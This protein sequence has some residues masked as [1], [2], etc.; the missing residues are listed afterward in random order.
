MTGDTETTFFRYWCRGE[1]ELKAMGTGIVGLTAHRD[2]TRAPGLRVVELTQLPIP[3]ELRG[4]NARYQAAVALCTAR[5]GSASQS[6]VEAR[7]VT[8]PRITPTNA[9]TA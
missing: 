5:E 3:D 8:P 6:A 2:G 9:S 4:T 1:A 7:N